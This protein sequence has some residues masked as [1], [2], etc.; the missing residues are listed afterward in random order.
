MWVA[1]YLVK[2]HGQP[3]LPLTLYTAAI[4]VSSRRVHLSALSQYK[5]FAAGSHL[6]LLDLKRKKSW[7]AKKTSTHHLLYSV[8]IHLH[9]SGEANFNIFWLCLFACAQLIRMSFLP[10]SSEESFMTADRFKILKWSKYEEKKLL[11]I[12]KFLFR[13]YC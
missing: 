3:V 12:T 10:F 6:A 9:Q 13:K 7:F 11:C 8:H 1:R 2:K 4:V 5:V